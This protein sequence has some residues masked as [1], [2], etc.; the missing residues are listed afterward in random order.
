MQFYLGVIA[1]KQSIGCSEITVCLL[2]IVLADYNGKWNNCEHTLDQPS[3]NVD[4]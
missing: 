1:T 2:T 4:L 3:I